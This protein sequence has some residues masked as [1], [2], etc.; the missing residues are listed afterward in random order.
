[1]SQQPQIT[2]FPF[3]VHNQ[4]TNEVLTALTVFNNCPRLILLNLD[5]LSLQSTSLIISTQ[6]HG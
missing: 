4:Q 3:P 6:L 2:L 5:S 1:M